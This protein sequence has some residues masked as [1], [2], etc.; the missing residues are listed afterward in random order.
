[1]TPLVLLAG[2]IPILFLSK[3]KNNMTKHFFMSLIIILFFS[4]GSLLFMTQYNLSIL[5]G[6]FIFMWITFN[7][8]YDLVTKYL[9]T[10]NIKTLF[11]NIGIK[12]VLR[13]RINM[14]SI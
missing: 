6:V 4:L 9:N 11:S 14:S 2:Y 1:M 7:I 13:H 10:R 8:L 5:L 12:C 3:R